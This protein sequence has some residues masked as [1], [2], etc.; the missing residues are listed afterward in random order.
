MTS[1]FVVQDRIMR[2][3]SAWPTRYR[4]TIQPVTGDS[5]EFYAVTW[6][7]PEKAVLMAA[8]ADGRGYGSSDGIYDVVVHE[9]GPAGRDQNGMVALDG[10]LC[11]R[12]EF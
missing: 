11:D 5:R 9:M 3:Q 4:I 8:Y 2:R 1:R 10:N 12:M 7:G 6:L